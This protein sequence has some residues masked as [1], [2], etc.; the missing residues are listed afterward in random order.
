VFD[1][2]G[3]WLGTVTTPPGLEVHEI[4]VDQIIGVAKDDYDV[5]YVQVHR[6]TRR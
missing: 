5:P 2:L 6:L 1:S 4:G 3:V